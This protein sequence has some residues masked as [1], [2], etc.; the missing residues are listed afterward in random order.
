MHLPVALANIPHDG[1]QNLMF[2]FIRVTCQ[3]FF[4][5]KAF[6]CGAI[7]SFLLAES[8]TSKADGR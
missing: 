4:K 3:L 1:E 2:D 8:L 7:Q 6:H 5:G